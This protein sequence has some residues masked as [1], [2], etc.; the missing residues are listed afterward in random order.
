[1]FIQAVPAA[2]GCASVHL[3]AA[4]ASL[5]RTGSS[6]K[7]R[8][9]S[10]PHAHLVLQTIRGILCPPRPRW[11]HGRSSAARRSP[12][13]TGRAAHQPNFSRVCLNLAALMWASRQLDFP[14]GSASQLG[15]RGLPLAVLPSARWRVMACGGSGADVPHC[16]VT[17]KRACLDLFHFFSPLLLS[18]SFGAV[19]AP[20]N[21]CSSLFVCFV[22]L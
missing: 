3:W 18:F 17:Q 4:R 8:A 11:I 22:S 7:G 10:S 5:H 6:E 1:M 14:R 19:T 15:R 9:C 13:H 16:A 21:S 12:S 2:A 20:A